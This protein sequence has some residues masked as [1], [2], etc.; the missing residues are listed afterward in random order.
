L[1]CAG[2]NVMRQPSLQIA[3]AIEI[4]KP[5]RKINGVVLLSQSAHLRED[6]GAKIG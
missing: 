6:G 4:R 5:L 3:R 1:I 2:G